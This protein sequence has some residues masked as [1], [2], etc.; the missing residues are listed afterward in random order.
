MFSVASVLCF[1][2]N[3]GVPKK[4]KDIDKAIDDLIDRYLNPLTDLTDTASDLLVPIRIFRS[5]FSYAKKIRFKSFLKHYCKAI[6]K[7]EL[8]EDIIKKFEKHLQKRENVNFI[9]QTIDD[10]IQ[11][12]S[13]YSAAVLGYICGSFLKNIREI[14]MKTLIII[15]AHF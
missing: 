8:T 9:Y 4:L 12:R 13:V 1:S 2:S 5:I 10:A 15:S 14:D 6:S 7:N 3:W 11:A